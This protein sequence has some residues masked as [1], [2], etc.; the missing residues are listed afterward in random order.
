MQG[1][2]IY[3]FLHQLPIIAIP[4][5]FAITLHEV[6]HGWVAKNLGD[7]TAYMLGRLTLNPIKHIDPLGTVI[8]PLALLLFSGGT[9]A[10]GWAKPVPVAFR[11]L[12][13]PRRDMILVA[14]AGPASNLLMATGWALIIAA[15]LSFLS[16][17]SVIDQWLYQMSGFGILINVVLAVFNLLPVPP[18]DGGRV[19]AG[20]LPPS[21]AR[22][23]DNI[24]PY[25]LLIV[26]ALMVTG[27]LWSILLPFVQVFQDF[28]LSFA[29]VR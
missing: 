27:I 8:V 29:G 6:A 21:G 23:L 4:M 5:L 17:G 3:G 10:F 11:N 2:D 12:R 1:V 14:A 28:F 20:L 22:V 24:E 16:F 18:L 15:L 13:N 7:P 19:L 25:G 26:V 9:M